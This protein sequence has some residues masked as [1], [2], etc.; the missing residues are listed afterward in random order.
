MAIC[1]RRS[2]LAAML[3]LSL[4]LTGCSALLE[5]DYSSVTPHNA[6]PTTEGDPSILRADS[7]Q[8]LVNAL[9]YFIS[10]GMEEGNVRLYTDAEN[11]EPFLSDACLEVVQE[12]PLGAYCVE[13]IK[14][15]V[16]PVVTYSEAHLS[17]T[18][19]R[20][21]EQ[22]AAIVQATGTA[23][24]RS[25]L[26]TALTS[27]APERTLRI[28]YFEEDEAFIQDLARQAYYD[29][30]A[31]ALGMP[32]VAVSIYPNSGRQ[33]IVEILLTYPLEPDQLEARRQELSQGLEELALELTGL[34]GQFQAQSAARELMMGRS[35]DPQGGNTAYDLFHDGRADSEGLALAYAA[36]CQQVGLSCQVA[37]GE[38]AG[39]PHFWNVVQTEAGWRH[40]DLSEE[41]EEGVSLYTDAELLE[42]GRFWE[43]GTLPACG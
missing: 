37:R 19:R 18:Y 20:T 41:A 8:E 2:L 14:Y 34:S 36:V 40:L 30:P 16:D 7:Y 21:R 3:A 33:R 22:V 43:E 5:R 24:I 38:L 32:E 25:E 28:S 9:I 11:V 27:F 13:F 6:A 1:G 10:G 23:A 15:T 12:D 35:F 29:A 17:I 31:C 39:E 42:L 26:G 4:V